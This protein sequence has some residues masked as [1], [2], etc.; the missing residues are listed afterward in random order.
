MTAD[1]LLSSMQKHQNET[2]GGSGV[3]ERDSLAELCHAS[4]ETVENLARILQ[5]RGA[6]KIQASPD[7][8]T[9]KIALLDTAASPGTSSHF[10]GGATGR[11][12]PAARQARRGQRRSGDR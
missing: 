9:V 2:E 8:T 1:Q 6:V 4:P 5:A 10:A 12:G 11:G 3:F 7:G